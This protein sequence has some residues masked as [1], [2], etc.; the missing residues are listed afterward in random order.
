MLS[1]EKITE[2][3]EK[4]GF[5]I[6]TDVQQAAVEVV[7][8][9]VSN[10]LQKDTVLNFLKTNDLIADSDVEKIEASGIEYFENA[11]QVFQYLKDRVE[12]DIKDYITK[13]EEDFI[14][15]ILKKSVEKFL[16]GSV[17]KITS[18]EKSPENIDDFIAKFKVDDEEYYQYFYSIGFTFR[19]IK[20]QSGTEDMYFEKIY[21]PQSFIN[22]FRADKGL[23]ANI[24]QYYDN[25]SKYYFVANTDD[26]NIKMATYTGSTPGKKEILDMFKTLSASK[27]IKAKTEA[28]L[29][30]AVKMYR[31]KAPSYTANDMFDEDT[32]NRVL[33]ENATNQKI[34][35]FLSFLSEN[36]IQIQQYIDNIDK[37]NT[38]KDLELQKESPAPKIIRKGSFMIYGKK[39]AFE[40]PLLGEN[41]YY[42]DFDEF[43][44]KIIKP[45]N[46][47]IGARNPKKLYL[48]EDLF[49]YFITPDQK[50]TLESLGMYFR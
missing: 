35:E 41:G 46:T 34:T 29:N 47:A 31:A 37:V 8:Q 23:T 50:T 32:R 43:F 3:Q 6:E 30:E 1:P 7:E 13:T 38:E 19:Q 21:F 39:V 28:E 24:Q 25:Q 16:P 2:L 27:L 4:V 11:Q 22:V 40:I 33:F 10:M 49:L 36:Q 14:S 17:L 9:A 20:E 26:F 15:D 48:G 44:E 5:Y 18:I 12:I 45:V 42:V